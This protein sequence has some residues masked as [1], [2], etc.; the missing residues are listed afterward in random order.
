MMRNHSLKQ[1][2]FY[3][4][5]LFIIN[6]KDKTMLNILIKKYIKNYEDVN[7][8][9]TKEA[10]GILASI[11]SIILNLLM[12]IFKLCFGFI[13]HSISMIADGLNNL[14]DMGSNLATFFGF[15]LANKHPDSEHPYGHGRIEYIVGMVIAFLIFYVGFTSL[16]DSIKKIFNPVKLNFS[17]YAVIVL[18][19]SIL[20]KLYMAHFNQKIGN[21]INSISLKAASRDSLNDVLVTCASLASLL[22]SLVSD[23]PFDGII[24]SV[25]SLLVIK[26]GIDIFKSTMDPLL[27][28]SP[29]K[30]L[31]KAIETYVLS[32]PFVLGI[33]DLMIHDYGPSRRYMTLHVEVNYKD[34]IMEIHDQIDLIERG[35]LKDFGILTTIHMDP[36]DQ[37]DEK[38]NNLRLM[39]TEIVK[40]INPT[41]SIHDFRIV[42]GPTHTNL[43][44]DVLL[45]SEDTIAH[46]VVRDM[47]ESKIKA[48]N[49]EYYCVI[50]IEHSYV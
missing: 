43:I 13:T 40:E 47:I 33:H 42:S 16:S 28:Q 32:Y 19:V 26:S 30:E 20:I 1:E 14:S 18:L 15:K 49:S 44:F 48:I 23:L 25:V 3:I 17:I 8:K 46:E 45:P 34:G 41:Y 5:L 21:L 37:D 6:N 7:H 11:L 35:I 50:E 38:T 22:L 12:V 24:G 36:I 29:D 31:V 10:Y 9:D 27:G 39:V 4:R 2:W